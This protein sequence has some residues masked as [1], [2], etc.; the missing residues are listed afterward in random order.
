[1]A[2]QTK[3]FTVKLKRTIQIRDGERDLIESQNHVNTI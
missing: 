1:M 2:L 3:H